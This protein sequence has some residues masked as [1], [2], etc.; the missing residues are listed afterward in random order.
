MSARWRLVLG[1]MLVVASMAPLLPLGL[2]SVA[3]GWYF[4][5]ILPATWTLEP[6]ARALSPRSDIPEAVVTTTAI[7]LAAFDQGAKPRPVVCSKTKDV[8]YELHGHRARG[9]RPGCET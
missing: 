3:R 7:A 1:L 5:Q 8:V 2:W 4:P 9:V 6:W